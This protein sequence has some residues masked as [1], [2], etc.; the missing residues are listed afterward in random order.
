MRLTWFGHSCFLLET[1]THRLLF[2]PWLDANP[3]SPVRAADVRC[4]FIF[5]S[6]AHEDHTADAL[7]LSRQNQAPII[8]PYELA[9]YLA[10]Q[11]ATTIDPMQG[12]SVDLPFGRVKLTPAVHS[13]TLE[14]G[15]G[16]FLPLGEPAGFVVFADD[17]KL[18]H[19][20]D[21]ALFSDMRL[22]GRIGLHVALLPIGDWYTM[23]IDDAVEALDLLTPKFAVPMHYNTHDK[24]RVDPQ[25][26]VSRAAAR[27]HTVR[28]LEPGDTWE[29]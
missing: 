26:F 18:Y 10:S 21:T 15:G 29:F 9:E 16:H 12:G 24:I 7:T 1:S 11:G 2:D 28:L 5:C 22:I 19:A 25:A 4:D 23:G 14:L 13:S 17:K 6:H 8:A 3:R 27:G 20:G